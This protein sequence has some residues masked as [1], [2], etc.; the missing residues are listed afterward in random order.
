[1]QPSEIS[2]FSLVL[3]AFVYFYLKWIFVNK[4]YLYVL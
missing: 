4:Q 2:N 3:L 1:M